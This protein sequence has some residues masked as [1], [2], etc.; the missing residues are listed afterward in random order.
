MLTTAAALAGGSKPPIDLQVLI[1]NNEII[2]P[3]KIIQLPLDNPP[4]MVN[5]D[6]IAIVSYKYLWDLQ[7]LAD[8]AVVVQFDNIGTNALE[9]ATRTGMGKIL[10]VLFR[11]DVDESSRIL[12]AAVI[13]KPLT[14]GK[15]RLEGLTPQEVK[16]IQQFIAKRRET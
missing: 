16:K 7:V 9:A 14:S 2:E 6:R 3:T 8:G 11:T 10:A 4:E 1:Q 15:L 13:D 5:F 12:L